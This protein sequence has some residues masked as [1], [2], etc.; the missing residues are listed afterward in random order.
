LPALRFAAR[1]VCGVAR[2]KA[3]SRAS[4]AVAPVVFRHLGEPKRPGCRPRGA[5]ETAAASNKRTLGAN[6]AARKLSRTMFSAKRQFASSLCLL[7]V[8]YSMRV[9]FAA[10]FRVVGKMRRAMSLEA[11]NLRREAVSYSD[12]A[13]ASQQQVAQM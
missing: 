10:R 9:R 1:H 6:R 3:R 4:G 5:A 12:T 8:A 11:V 2:Q 13:A 7:G